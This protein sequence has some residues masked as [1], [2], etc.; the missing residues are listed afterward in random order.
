M[1]KADSFE[2]WLNRAKS[3]L[4]RT[5][6]K[7]I[8]DDVYYEDICYDAQQCAE[9][10]LKALCIFHSIIF[11]KTHDLAHLLEL[12]INNNINIPIAIKKA[13]DL[14]DYSVETRYPGDYPEVDEKECKQVIKIAENVFNWVCKEVKYNI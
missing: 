13:E 8:S 11:P 5:D 1:T 4:A 14:S 10:S 6:L 7:N 9:K 12:L 2:K 3:N